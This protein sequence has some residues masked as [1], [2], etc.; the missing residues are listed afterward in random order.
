VYCRKLE[1]PNLSLIIP[2]VVML[3]KG[4]LS[5]IFVL[6]KIQRKEQ[7]T[8]HATTPTSNIHLAYLTIQP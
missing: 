4:N 3:G 5:G 6:K 8:A 1:I 7:H 2:F